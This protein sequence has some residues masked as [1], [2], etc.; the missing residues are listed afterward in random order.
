MIVDICDALSLCSSTFMLRPNTVLRTSPCHGNFSMPLN[1]GL[2]CCCHHPPGGPQYMLPGRRHVLW[3]WNYSTVGSFNAGDSTLK[4]QH[5]TSKA[6]MLDLQHWIYT[7]TMQA[8]AFRSASDCV[9]HTVKM[10]DD[11]QQGHCQ[12]TSC[13]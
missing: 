4:F 6:C 13:W 9:T 1:T 5:C 8:E 12:Q 2:C 7:S 3:Y 11:M 10:P